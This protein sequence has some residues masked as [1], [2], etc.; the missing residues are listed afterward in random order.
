[1]EDDKAGRVI[2]MRKNWN[3]YNILVGKP[4]G[5]R[6]LGSRR[7]RLKDNIKMDLREMRWSDT[8]RLIWLRIG[9]N[10]FPM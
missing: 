2:R 1:M 8:T 7:R 5:E 4:E 9:T 3:M 6:Q 10:G